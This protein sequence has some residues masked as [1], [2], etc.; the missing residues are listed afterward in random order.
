MTL[1]AHP[2][3]FL[4]KYDG[5]AFIGAPY[6]PG[7]IARVTRYRPTVGVC[8]LSERLVFLGEIPRGTDFE[9][10]A[11]IGTT[12]VEGRVEAD[13]LRDDSALVY[14]NGEGIFIITG[15]SH[16]GICNIIYYAKKVCGEEHIHGVLGGFH[17]LEDLPQLDQTIAYLKANRIDA[18]YPCHCVSLLTKAKMMSVLPV[19]EVG[20]GI[21]IEIN[22]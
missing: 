8:H 4:P 5:E 18:V 1:C 15:C 2:H 13:T 10:R 12:I 3:C 21:V 6:N 7:E 17:L 19:Q 20:A 22:T 9:A 11:H 14:Q 16:S